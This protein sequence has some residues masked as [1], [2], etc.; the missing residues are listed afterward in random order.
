METQTAEINKLDQMTQLLQAPQTPFQTNLIEASP[1]APIDVGASVSRDCTISNPCLLTGTEQLSF[2]ENADGTLTFVGAGTNTTS[3]EGSSISNT[4][5]SQLEALAQDPEFQAEAKQIQTLANRARKLAQLQDALKSN[6][7]P[8]NY[9]TLLKKAKAYQ[10]LAQ[11]IEGNSTLTR[12]NSIVLNIAKKNYLDPVQPRIKVSSKSLVGRITGKKSS[13]EKMTL[14]K[15]FN[16][17]NFTEK[18]NST[19]TRQTAKKIESTPPA[20]NTVSDPASTQAAA[21]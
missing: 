12:L 7:N 8:D 9:N 5:A 1:D 17:K 21:G 11:Q 10:T 3:A 2:T 15:E 20:S 16:L 18:A 13:V 4:L 19:T 6:P 14:D